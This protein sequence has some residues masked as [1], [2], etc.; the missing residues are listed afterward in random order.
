MDLDKIVRRLEQAFTIKLEQLEARAPMS[1]NSY[2]TSPRYTKDGIRYE[3]MTELCLS[4]IHFENFAALEPVF[5]TLRELTLSECSIP[6]AWELQQIKLRYLTLEKCSISIDPEIHHTSD[7]HLTTLRLNEIS[8]AG[9]KALTPVFYSAENLYLSHCTLENMSP[10]LYTD[11]V[12]NLYLDNVTLPHEGIF[13]PNVPKFKTARRNFEYL[14]L[15]NMNIPH[16]GFFLPISNNLRDI[17]F[18]QC[19]VGNLCE[20][21]LF[22][23]LYSLY[24]DDTHFITSATDIPYPRES[25]IKLTHLEF[26]NMKLKDFDFITPISAGLTVLRL[27]NCEVERLQ[28]IDQFSDLKK[29]YVDATL[30]VTDRSIP[31]NTA[32]S[33]E[34]EECIIEPITYDRD[35]TLPLPDFNTELLVSIAS[36]TRNVSI[37][38]NNLIN[39]HY[40]K[41]FTRLKELYFEKCA[42]DLDHY[43][44]IAPQIQQLEFRTTAITNQNAFRYFTNLE[45]LK[46]S[47]NTPDIGPIDFNTLL[48]LKGHLKK[49][50]ISDSD[51]M[52]L[53]ENVD[54]LKHFT[55]LEKL[56]ITANSL[57]LAQDVLSIKSLQELE[58][59][60]DEQ[61]PEVLETAMLDVQQLKSLEKL[62][63]RPYDPIPI[64]GL[65]H[66]KSLKILHL[67]SDADVENLGALPLLEKLS[68]EGG[69]VLHKLPR[70]EQVKVLDITME[71]GCEV[72]SLKNF[73]NLEKLQLANT[74]EEQ[75][76]DISGLEKLKVLVYQC[77]DNDTIVAF[78]NL[79]GL[80][81][82]DLCYRG[83]TVLPKLDKLTN[84]KKL[85]LSENQIENIEGLE[86]LKNLEYLNLYRN[87]IADFSPL[88]KL[89]KL[90]EVNVCANE[91][92]KEDIQQQLD[93][94]EIVVW[95]GLPHS[96]F[97]ILID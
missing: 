86:N 6:D 54:V 26:Y 12:E 27:S 91:L 41:H 11:F 25:E 87:N 84:L 32:G 88:N 71:E 75:K 46:F 15:K 53:L 28:S 4:Q 81:E 95:Y 79:P 18:L 45:V 1:G 24:V 40:L 30:H 62:H 5:E 90:R 16:P 2:C 22:P 74:E 36:Y 42:I 47:T 14:G 43:T 29:L 57:E 83:I 93:K 52:E 13:D 10:F 69:E 50:N 96:H 9:L 23:R 35:E 17:S 3:L 92:K 85:D 65:G 20:L 8:F 70:L 89:P 67:N 60:I 48:P 21:N 31:N 82:L 33:F 80:E 77:Y 56:E 72:T 66:L 55:A 94:P 37:E 76:I 49:L 64:K 39:T 38:G 61:T 34:L 44:C 97:R 59:Y 78:E 68:I 63:I 19:T 51:V 73:P 7:R 58:L